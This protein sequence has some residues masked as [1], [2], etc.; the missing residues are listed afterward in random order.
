MN[1]K[2]LIDRAINHR[3]ESNLTAIAVIAGL[4]AGAAL[5]VIF[6]P[7]SGKESR[8]ALCDATGSILDKLKTCSAEQVNDAS[9]SNEVEDVREKTWE[10]A[11]HLQGPENKR[12]NPTAIHV[13]S[14]GTSAWKEN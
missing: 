10:N 9:F 3:Q 6:A 14:A 12:K 4:A 13:P 8:A 1:Y 11:E 7:R 2:K 5:G